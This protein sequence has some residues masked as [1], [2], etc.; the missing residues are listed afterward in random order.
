MPT[1]K[2]TLR[3]VKFYS[4]GNIRISL[5]KQKIDKK[6]LW[7]LIKNGNELGSFD[8]QVKGL[9]AWFEACERHD[10]VNTTEQKTLF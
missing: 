4:T 10:G 9:D 1:E 3:V 5:E 2:R 7:T 6:I 8:S